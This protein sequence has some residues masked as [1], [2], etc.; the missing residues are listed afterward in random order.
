MSS[1]TTNVLP[2]NCKYRPIQNNVHNS[3]VG[4]RILELEVHINYIFERRRLYVGE[5]LIRTV[6]CTCRMLKP[7]QLPRSKGKTNSICVASNYQWKFFFYHGNCGV[8]M[9]ITV[10]CLFTGERPKYAEL[11]AEL[12][13]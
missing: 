10:T 4:I 11:G 8:F 7:A 5:Q 9:Q 1:E 2:L 3:R 13:S 6:Q 12:C